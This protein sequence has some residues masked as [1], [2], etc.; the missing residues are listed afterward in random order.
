M[1]NIII[2]SSTAVVGGVMQL[3]CRR[4]EKRHPEVETQ[5]KR[6]KRRAISKFIS[7]HG[8]VT[9]IGVGVTTIFFKE[10]FILL[11]GKLS[12]TN[13]EVIIASK[14]KKSIGQI[15]RSK[16]AILSFISGGVIGYF[17]L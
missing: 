15:A 3:T 8:L 1:K 9:G 13:S 2:I 16:D 14:P 5:G 11:K 6:S 4:Y 7:E 12:S 10:G 17:F